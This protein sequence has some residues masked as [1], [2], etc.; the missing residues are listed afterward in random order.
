M[1]ADSS[2]IHMVRHDPINEAFLVSQ[3][4]SMPPIQHH[5]LLD[6]VYLGLEVRYPQPEPSVPCTHDGFST[7]APTQGGGCLAGLARSPWS[8]LVPE[9]S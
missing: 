6:E 3:D 2:F 7:A 5:A 8:R 9:E 4:V 1:I